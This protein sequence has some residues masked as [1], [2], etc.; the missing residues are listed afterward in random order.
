MSVDLQNEII[1]FSII[2]IVVICL[3]LFYAYISK[4]YNK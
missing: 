2:T 4:K 1:S 3:G